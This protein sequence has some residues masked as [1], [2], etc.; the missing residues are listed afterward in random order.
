VTLALWV[1]AV[2]L[3]VAAFL[4]CAAAMATTRDALDAET[5]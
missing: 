4:E 3:G 1:S 2:M 5:V